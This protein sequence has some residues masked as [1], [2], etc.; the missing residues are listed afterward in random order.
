MWPHIRVRG[1]VEQRDAEL[2]VGLQG[3]GSEVGDDD[4]NNDNVDNDDVIA[5]APAAAAAAPELLHFSSMASFSFI[6]PSVSSAIHSYNLLCDGLN[7]YNLRMKCNSPTH[8]LLL[9]L[10]LLN[11]LFLLHLSYCLLL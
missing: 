9:L 6:Y 5:S 1:H 2:V 10:I 11:H 8:C 7:F 4:D 3:E